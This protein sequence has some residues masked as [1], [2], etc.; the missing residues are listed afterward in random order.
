M[1]RRAEADKDVTERKMTTMRE[2]SDKK[3]RKAVGGGV[4]RAGQ[5]MTYDPK[6]N[7]MNKR[8]RG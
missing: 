3:G 6:I 2:A 1:R 5:I 7:C 8:K 4:S